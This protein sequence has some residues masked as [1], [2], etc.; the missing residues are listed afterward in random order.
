MLL[1][2][3]GASEL[4]AQ[5]GTGRVAGTVKDTDGN[6]VAGATVMAEMTGTD[7]QL[8]A[9][10]DEKGRW[11][12]LGFRKGNY[13]FTFTAK[14]Y[15]PQ[16]FSTQVSGLGKNPNVN[17][18]MEKMTSGQAFAAGEAAELM[19]EARGLYDAKDFAGALTKYQE[20]LTTYPDIYQINVYLGNCNRELGNLDEALANYNIVLTEEPLN[21]VA[22]VNVGD[23]YVRK[24]DF[25]HA[26]TYFEQALEQA[27]EDEVLPFNV[28][29]I[30]FDQGDVAGA[31]EYYKRAA[32]VKADW[33]EPQL[34]LGYAYIN[35]ADMENAA[36][37]FK[38]VIEMAPDTPQA[39]VAQAALDSIQQ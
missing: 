12:I 33:V 36:I 13:S 17:V 16:Q 10:T 1:L 4:S 6:D 39:A 28:A 26:V 5:M 34:K 31:I 29:E 18:V 3:T 20:I 38:K 7:F 30:Y 22:L 19:K 32:A 27:P 15:I 35:M 37:H 25:E 23:V 11:A 24:G 21:T 9:T 14:G 2:V 8:E